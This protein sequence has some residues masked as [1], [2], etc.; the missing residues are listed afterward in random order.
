MAFLAAYIILGLNIFSF[1]GEYLKHLKKITLWTTI[2][3]AIL[4]ISRIIE[5]AMI[6]SNPSP[7]TRYN[8]IRLVRFIAVAIILL[9]GVSLLFENWYTAAVS[10]GLISLLVGFALQTPI[11]S[12]IGWLYIVIRTPYHVG[13][14]IQI[15]TF[16]G[17]VVEISYLD[18]TLWEFGGDYLTNDLPSGRLIRFPN[19]LVLQSAVFNYSWTTFPY[20]W[21]EIPFHFAYE[22]DLKLIEEVIKKVTK[23][24]L[25]QDA[26]EK[27]ENLKN[28]M[29]HTPVSQVDVKEY[30]FVAFRINTNTWVEASVTYL[31]NPKKAADTRSRIIKKVLAELNKTPD[32]ALFPKS[33]AR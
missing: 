29:A 12:L 22:S 31:V 11:T 9:V 20:L 8:L 2:S 15:D 26:D 1:F 18:T 3:F 14:R 21:N 19:S 4:S 10:L 5:H 33:N 7:A 6:G 25:E 28:Y 17:D 16:K 32:R 13:D 30:P 27:I 23:A 24:E